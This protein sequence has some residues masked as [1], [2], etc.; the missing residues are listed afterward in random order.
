MRA[1]CTA[2]ERNA[3]GV[4]PAVSR[5]IRCPRSSLSFT[6]LAC[7]LSCCALALGC[8]GQLHSRADAG[9]A[10]AMRDAA[11][12]FDAAV[13]G[14]AGAPADAAPDSA[15]VDAPRGPSPI[16]LE[17]QLPGSDSL[18]LQHPAGTQVAAYVSPSSV[19]A[20]EQVRLF[21]NVDHD[22]DVHWELFRVGDYQNHGA[23]L[24]ATGDPRARE[25][26]AGLPAERRHRPDRL[27]LGSGLSAADSR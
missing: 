17:N 19:A 22:Q 6:R 25:R 11:T 9:H 23:R 7:A 20:G 16:Q 5:S 27:P 10:P 26:A 13:S 21:V 14:D 18:A 3:R 2:R 24:I 4:S 12:A 15:A 8:R 1:R